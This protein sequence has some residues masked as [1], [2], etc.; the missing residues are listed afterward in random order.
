MPILRYWTSPAQNSRVPSYLYNFF[1]IWLK[2][3]PGFPSAGESLIFESG[4]MPWELE[5]EDK[6]LTAEVNST[7]SMSNVLHEQKL[8][9][10]GLW[11][12]PPLLLHGSCFYSFQKQGIKT[13]TSAEK[14]REFTR[15]FLSCS[16]HLKL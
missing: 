8:E 5:S 4:F 12:E 15:L 13:I 6:N 14:Y 11:H 7:K 9:T 2:S 1:I 3:I 16:R 10:K